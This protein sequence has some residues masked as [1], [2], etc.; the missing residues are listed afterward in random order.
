MPR[1]TTARPRSVLFVE[2]VLLGDEVLTLDA[3]QPI[4]F[5]FTDRLVHVVEASLYGVPFLLTGFRRRFNI[6][7]DWNLFC[8]NHAI[9]KPE[10][11]KE[12]A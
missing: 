4:V 6:G 1:R 8:R 2:K 11:Q 7:H 5:E 12:T 9:D 10:D 3:P